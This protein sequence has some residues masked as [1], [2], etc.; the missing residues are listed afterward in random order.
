MFTSNCFSLLIVYLWH[1]QEMK[2]CGQYCFASAINSN[3][4]TIFSWSFW[5]NTKC[6]DP[7][8]IIRVLPQVLWL[9]NATKGW[10]T[11]FVP[12]NHNIGFISGILLE[13]RHQLANSWQ[14]QRVINDLQPYTSNTSSS[15]SDNPPWQIKLE[16]S[17]GWNCYSQREWYHSP[18][19][20]VPY[21]P[22]RQMQ[23][24]EE[25]VDQ[26]SGSCSVKHC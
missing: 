11:D 18:Q 22:P 9:H 7:T 23:G 3:I 13:F 2:P 24:L 12:V 6:N 26:L 5:N 10:K 4:W 8:Y 20:H 14:F 19:L 25:H 1:R 17:L 21:K 15:R 16:G